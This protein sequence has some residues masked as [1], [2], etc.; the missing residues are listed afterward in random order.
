[1]LISLERKSQYD[2]IYHCYDVEIRFHD[3]QDNDASDSKAVR[4]EVLVSELV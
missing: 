2:V 4:G 3:K 1:M